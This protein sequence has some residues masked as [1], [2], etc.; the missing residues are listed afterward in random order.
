MHS[1]AV[2]PQ[3]AADRL[4]DVQRVHKRP[5]RRAVTCHRNVV[6]DPRQPAQIVEHDVEPHPR[7]RPERGRIPQERR[8]ELII[9]HRGQ[10]VF[11]QRLALGIGRQRVK[12]LHAAS[13]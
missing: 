6:L 9:G 5:P 4:R 11:D 12:N 10:V 3:D 8:R 13:G 1:F 2:G 7:R